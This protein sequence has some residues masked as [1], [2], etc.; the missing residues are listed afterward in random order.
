MLVLNDG[1]FLTPD[2]PWRDKV[3]SIPGRPIDS[4]PVPMEKSTPYLE[5][6]LSDEEIVLEIGRRNPFPWTA[7]GRIVL[8]GEGTV[9]IGETCGAPSIFTAEW[10]AWTFNRQYA[11]ADIARPVEIGLDPPYPK[12]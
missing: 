3:A 8:D 7:K 5:G 1:V 10:V 4:S 2:P 11:E 6:W 12:E 9:V